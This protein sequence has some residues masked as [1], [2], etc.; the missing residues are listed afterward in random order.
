MITSGYEDQTFHYNVSNVSYIFIT[1]LNKYDDWSTR[2]RVNPRWSLVYLVIVWRIINSN[3][4]LISNLMNDIMLRHT[5]VVRA[6]GFPA[7]LFAA[8]IIN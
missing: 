4:P 7:P 3:F 5:T 1:A 8:G 6:L 2:C